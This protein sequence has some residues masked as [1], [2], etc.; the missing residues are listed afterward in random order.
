MRTFIPSFWNNDFVYNEII[1]SK[2]KV[3]NYHFDSSNAYVSP[4]DMYLQDVFTEAIVNT[5]SKVGKGC[6]INL[7][8]TVD[9]EIVIENGV[10]LCVRCIV[11]GEKRISL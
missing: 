5:G 7:G 3:E 2:R 1:K 8:A 4:K 9:H 10:H 6:I 11:K